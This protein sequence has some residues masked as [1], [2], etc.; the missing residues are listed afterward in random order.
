[1]VGGSDGC[2]A[3][4]GAGAVN[5]GDA[6]GSIGTSGAV[7]VVAK[8]PYTDRKARAFCYALTKYLYVSG[9]AV[10]SGGVVL[11]WFRDA[12]GADP[13]SG[14]A[15]YD[16]LIAEGSVIPPG[17][18]GLVFLPYLTGERSPHWNANA[19]G[20]FF[21]V[22][23][24]HTRSHFSRAVLEGIVYGLYSVGK[25]IEEISGPIRVI[26]ANGGFT[27]SSFWVQMLADVFNRRV[28]VSEES[29]HDAAKGAY[30]IAMN[31]LERL[32]KFESDEV[33]SAKV[34]YEPNE[35]VHGLYMKNFELFN[36]LYD[37]IKD[38]F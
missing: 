12:F 23:L 2:L 21:G 27:Q 9:G 19:K 34:V 25:I 20:L 8:S 3:N 38:E 15:T 14:G 6:V 30:I 24:H 32:S 4:L 10:N 17:A 29:V 7:R 11:R 28:V 31:A 13:T 36:R 18:D 26:Y 16:Q 37:R 33:E 35:S 1:M 5:P 22:Q